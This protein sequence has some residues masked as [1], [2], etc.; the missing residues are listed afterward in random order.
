MQ[1]LN[2]E[3]ITSLKVN[4]NGL[5]LSNH[6]IRLAKGDECTSLFLNELSSIEVK[7]TT[8][9][10]WHVATFIG[11]FLSLYGYSHYWMLTIILGI[12]LIILGIGI[13]IFSRTRKFIITSRGGTKLIFKLQNIS[14]SNALS[15]VDQIEE[16]KGTTNVRFER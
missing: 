11:L 3:G 7:Y 14:A 15:L 12:V 8:E 13:Y 2:N 6:R 5:M 10:F 16:M 4:V 9:P 1:L